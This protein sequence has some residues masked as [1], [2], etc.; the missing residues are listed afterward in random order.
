[1]VDNRFIPK[2]GSIDNFAL[3]QYYVVDIFSLIST[4][5]LTTCLPKGLCLNKKSSNPIFQET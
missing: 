4:Y 3:L 1:M 5:K 2:I